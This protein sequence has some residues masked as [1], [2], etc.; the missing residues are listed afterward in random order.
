MVRGAWQLGPCYTLYLIEAGSYGKDTRKLNR[1]HLFEKVEV[2]KIT[3]PE[4][5]S[6]EIETL[7]ADAEEELKLL[8]LPYLVIILCRG[9][10]GFSGAKT[11]ATWAEHLS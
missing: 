5:L 1:Q 9:N 7:L 10:L 11:L 3:T 2:V 8:Q 4:M 6:H